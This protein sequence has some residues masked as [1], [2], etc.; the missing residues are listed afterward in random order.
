MVA[1]RRPAGLCGQWH[2]PRR[3][4]FDTRCPSGYYCRKVGPPRSR[5]DVRPLHPPHPSPPPAPH[6]SRGTPHLSPARRSV[7][8]KI[9]ENVLFIQRDVLYNG[10]DR[11]EPSRWAAQELLRPMHSRDAPKF[12]AAPHPRVFPSLRV[13]PGQATCGRV[14]LCDQVRDGRATCG[15]RAGICR[16]GNVH[17]TWKKNKAR[18]PKATALARGPAVTDEVLMTGQSMRGL[19]GS[20]GGHSAGCLGRAACTRFAFPTRWRARVRRRT[21]AW[22]GRRLAGCSTSCVSVAHA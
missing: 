12:R 2:H 19:R 7:S 21:G 9:G 13:A 6:H 5:D 18:L 22:L 10:V 17:D 3:A 15:S 16:G 4:A 20:G 14:L 8:A 1:P 11:N